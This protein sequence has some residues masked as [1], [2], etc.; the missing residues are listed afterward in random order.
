MVESIQEKK[1][2]GKLSLTP[3]LLL[4]LNIMHCW[5]LVYFFFLFF[6]MASP[7]WRNR[8]V[9]MLYLLDFMDNFTITKSCKKHGEQASSIQ[10]GICQK[11]HGLT[12]WNSNHFIIF[13]HL[14][15]QF[16][17]GIKWHFNGFVILH[18]NK[19]KDISLRY[20]IWFNFFPFPCLRR[21]CNL[22][23]LISFQT[24]D[25]APPSLA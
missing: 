4:K 9:P 8:G 10:Y 20:L 7:M 2:Q 15:L 24:F 13:I 19:L 1:V 18:E 16:D 14:L 21:N 23:D 5:K 3:N 11:F 12:I 25:N 22:Q 6:E 17:F